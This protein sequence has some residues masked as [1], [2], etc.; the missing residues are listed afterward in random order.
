LTFHKDK[1]V[2]VAEGPARLLMLT[3]PA[4]L[5]QLPCVNIG[6]TRYAPGTYGQ[7]AIVPLMGGRM[8]FTL[9]NL[10]QPPVFRTWQQW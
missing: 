2:A 7:W 3:Q 6:G 1:V 8:E 9:E 10:P 4:G 5:T